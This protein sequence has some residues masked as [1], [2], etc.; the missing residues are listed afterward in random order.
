MCG[1]QR[2]KKAGGGKKVHWKIEKFNTTNAQNILESDTE[3]L[4]GLKVS[5]N[6]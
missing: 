6:I 3:T 1:K 2:K 5:V 4:T